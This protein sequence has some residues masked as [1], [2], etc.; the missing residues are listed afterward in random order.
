MP[1]DGPGDLS[2]EHKNSLSDPA[3][4]DQDLLQF[5][6]GQPELWKS[7]FE[8]LFPEG[9]MTFFYPWLVRVYSSL[10]QSEYDIP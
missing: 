10:V 1:W 3:R 7:S 2:R 5:P 8:E 4:C 6:K 9:I